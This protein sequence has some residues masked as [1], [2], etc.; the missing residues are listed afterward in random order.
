MLVRT[1][2]YYSGF[3]CIAGD[4]T[5][6]CC[7]GWQVDVDDS[8]FAYYRTVQGEFGDRLRSVMT[9]GRNGSEGQFRIRE[10]G[11][12]PFL[13]DSNLCDLYA[14]LGEDA[15]CVT[16]AQYP[17][18][19]CEFGSLRETG[20]ALSCKTAAELILKDNRT[21][22]FVTYED[23]DSFPALNNIDGDLFLALMKARDKA[24]EIISDREQNIFERMV[25]LLDFAGQIQSV[26][27]KPDKIVSL[28][29]AC[30]KACDAL[31]QNT[32]KL[33]EKTLTK[34]FR[35]YFHHYLCQ[36]IIKPEW[37]ALC[38]KVDAELYRGGYG[39]T[40][41]TFW[42]AYRDKEYEYEN[43]LTYFTF[44]YFMKG[45]FDGDV[46]TKV[47]MGVVSTLMIMQCDMACWRANG[48]SFTLKEQVEITHLYSREVE[49]SEE[50]FDA[51]C[52][53]FRHKKEFRTDTLK[54][55][56]ISVQGG[57]SR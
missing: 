9:E 31:A 51:L 4:C 29:G 27:K 8:S 32:E 44:R 25:F 33:S 10:D 38:E 17:R 11:R 5:D 42:E 18:Y 21:P 12:C 34:I 19:S 1:P 43:L 24:Y 3:K 2:D 49:H 20:I 6:T 26:I 41:G 50:N 14:A 53:I 16:C 15:L 56:C 55:L 30:Q 7:A 39:E 46:L 13:N 22:G 54:K 57:I 28:T 48:G 36:V 35:K 45:V 23:E 37:P 40:A 52:R 47:K